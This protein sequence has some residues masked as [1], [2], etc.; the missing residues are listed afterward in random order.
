[1]VERFCVKAFHHLKLSLLEHH[2]PIG[3]WTGVGELLVNKADV[4]DEAVTSQ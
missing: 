3:L 2:V 4:N 1:M